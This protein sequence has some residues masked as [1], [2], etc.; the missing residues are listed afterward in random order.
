MTEQNQEPDYGA[1]ADR[2]RRRV[3]AGVRGA[4]DYLRERADTREMFDRLAGTQGRVVPGASQLE[5]L[6]MRILLASDHV[7]PDDHVD[8][9]VLREMGIE[10]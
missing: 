5:E 3:D 8:H 6:V 7:T 4:A 10:Q 9:E 2:V 1:I